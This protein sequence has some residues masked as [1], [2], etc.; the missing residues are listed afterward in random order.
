M[1]VAIVDYGMGNLGSVRRA[2]IELHATVEIASN[3]EQLAEADRIILPGVGS[4][5]DGMAS[6]SQYGWVDALRKQVQI[7]GKPLLGICLGMQL[8]STQGSEGNESGSAG[9]G[10]IPGN[11]EHLS[12]L[13]CALRIP[14]VGWNSVNI[15]G[16][17]A[18]F[19]GIPEQTDFY[20]V[21]SFA[22]TP[23]SPD[24]T[25]STVDYDIPVAAA[26]QSGVVFGTQFHPEKSSKA[27]L[28][29]LRNFLE[30][31]AC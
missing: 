2:M 23:T 15:I 10:L 13:G 29:L 27:G 7:C 17:P 4:F 21:H 11:V 9:L 30:F 8:L 20:F 26:I 16:E 5:S 3:P 25:L 28:R 22:F 24:H 19:S 12:S 14:H 6:L 31:T 1:K 18:I